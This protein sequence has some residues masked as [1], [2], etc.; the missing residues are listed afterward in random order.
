MAR[1]ACFGEQTLPEVLASR[2]VLRIISSTRGEGLKEGN[3][4]ASEVER[5]G[6]LDLV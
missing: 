6:W 3:K 1:S 2:A 5:V 4:S